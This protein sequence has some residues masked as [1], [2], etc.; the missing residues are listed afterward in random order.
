MRVRVPHS[1]FPKWVRLAGGLPYSVRLTLVAKV[2]V[3]LVSVVFGLTL[4][5]ADALFFLCPVEA[6]FCLS[7]P[8]QSFVFCSQGHF[9]ADKYTQKFDELRKYCK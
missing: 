2:T 5:G 1:L 8:T 4:Y 6:S 3:Q 7:P 9:T